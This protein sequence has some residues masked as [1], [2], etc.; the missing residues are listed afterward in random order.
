M[1]LEGNIEG[2]KQVFAP[3]EFVC[4]GPVLEG[5]IPCSVYRS[6][7]YNTSP[8]FVTYELYKPN[9]FENWCITLSLAIKCI[10]QRIHCGL[11]HGAQVAQGQ[12]LEQGL[13]SCSHR[14][15]R[16]FCIRLPGPVATGASSAA[17][18][19]GNGNC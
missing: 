4:L 3:L 2:V 15:V 13:G 7:I 1:G 5:F 18:G 9:Y 6:Q 11:P 19:G 16:S 8:F 12:A 10:E 17:P 14:W